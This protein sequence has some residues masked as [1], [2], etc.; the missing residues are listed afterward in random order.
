M[1]NVKVS[2]SL[3]NPGMKEQKESQDDHTRR[4]QIESPRKDAMV[5]RDADLTGEPDLNEACLNNQKDHGV[6]TDKEKNRSSSSNPFV[7][8]ISFEDLKEEVR[9]MP[10]FPPP[11][12]VRTGSDD[13][14]TGC[15]G[16]RPGSRAQTRYI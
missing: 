10:T 12:F 14:G 16:T 15:S 2:K 5:L 8:R 1:M 7:T 9:L 11:D 4:Q 6:E 3:E 13:S